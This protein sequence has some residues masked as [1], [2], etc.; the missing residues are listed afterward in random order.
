[1][2]FTLFLATISINISKDTY[3]LTRPKIGAWVRAVA[4]S[5]DARV[6]SATS[7]Y[8]VWAGVWMFFHTEAGTLRKSA[9]ESCS[10]VQECLRSS[11]AERVCCMS[12]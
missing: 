9:S 8:S 10:F 6:S 12:D 3:T 7:I 5:A 4:V 11:I 1:M 2:L